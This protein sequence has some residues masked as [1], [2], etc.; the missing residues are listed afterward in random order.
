MNNR[1]KLESKIRSK[2][3]D[4]QLSLSERQ[5]R[6]DWNL[7]AQEGILTYHLPDNLPDG[8]ALN[9]KLNKLMQTNTIN[10]NDRQ[11]W[12]ALE[13]RFKQLR[14][15]SDKIHS[16]CLYILFFFFQFNFEG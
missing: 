1:K 12:A 14:K 10:L 9:A 5:K 3:N 16:L 8:I 6:T 7:K 4:S 15:V 11:F 2:L 13:N